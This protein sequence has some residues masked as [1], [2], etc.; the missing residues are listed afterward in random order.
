MN[1]KVWS[2]E[3]QP[4]HPLTWTKQWLLQVVLSLLGMIEKIGKMGVNFI[5]YCI[6]KGIAAGPGSNHYQGLVDLVLPRPL[7]RGKPGQSLHPFIKQINKSCNT[8]TLVHPH[9]KGCSRGTNC[10]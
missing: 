5:L 9:S 1:R 6:W 4:P 8:I 10:K 3:E 2:S 7:P